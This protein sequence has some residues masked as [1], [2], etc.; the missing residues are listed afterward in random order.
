MSSLK[1]LM[2]N[3]AK[4]SASASQSRKSAEDNDEDASRKR[5]RHQ[6]SVV[7]DREEETYHGPPHYLIIG[8]Q[9]AG[10][11][12]AVKNLNKHPQVSCLSEVHYFDLGWHAKTK[13]AYRDM[14]KGPK[15]MLG[16]KTPELIY[17]DECLVSMTVDHNM[18]Y[19]QS[20]YFT[21]A[22]RSL[23]PFLLPPL[24]Y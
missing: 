6:Q 3:Y 1:D 2:S 18:T 17:V 21:L 11:M 12:A 16:E 13:T 10:T 22:N 23:T 19:Y 24:H 8:A 9:K 15:L 14:F 4:S 7:A 5:P 20:N